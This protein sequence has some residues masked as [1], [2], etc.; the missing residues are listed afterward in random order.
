MR[1]GF[2]GVAHMHANGYAAALRWREDAAAAL[3]WDHD[4]ARAQDFAHAYG[5]ELADSAESLVRTCDAVIVTSE[6]NRHIDLLEMAHEAGIPALCEKPILGKPDDVPRLET[7]IANLARIMTAFP[8]RYSS[9]FSRLRQRV[10]N[11]ELGSIRSI[12]ATNRGRCPFDW[13]VDV[14]ESGGGAMID[15]VVHVADLLFVLLKAAPQSVHAVTGNNMYGEAWEDTAMLTFD[16]AN[17]VFATID[18]SWSRPQSYK[19]WGDVTMNVVGDNGVIELDLFGQQF[20][21]YGAGTPS[22]TLVGYGSDIDSALVGDFLSFARGEKDCPIT[23]EDGLRAVQ[24]AFAGYESVR[25]GQP[26]TMASLSPV[27]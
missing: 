7:L 18:S 9:A 16:Y 19:T 27:S 11:S 23:A 17:G 22:H 24:A 26:V 4:L 8:C 12:S 14:A 25:T 1:I 13:F 3:V 6:N 5:P 21:I 10:E 15:H 2:L 20:D